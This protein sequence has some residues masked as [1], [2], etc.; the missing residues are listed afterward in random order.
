[1]SLLLTIPVG[2]VVYG[3]F[4]FLLRGLVIDDVRSLLAR[5]KRVAW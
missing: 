4:V 5:G 3:S 2:M 1:V